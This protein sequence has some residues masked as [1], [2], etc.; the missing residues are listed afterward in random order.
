VKVTCGIDPGKL[1]ALAWISDVA[2]QVI[3]MPVIRAAKGRHEYDLPAIVSLLKRSHV[4]TTVYL[5]RGQPL[6][7]ILR[8]KPMGGASANYHRGY[9]RGL[10]EGILTALGIPY[11]LVSPRSWQKEMLQGTSGKD[12]KQRSVI[13]AQRLFPGV[14]LLPTE[15][16]RKASDGMA[17]SLLIAEHGRRARGG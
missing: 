6:P 8:G 12:T 17:D 7:R 2:V 13:A 9:S 11:V 4:S 3:P 5:E 1:G 15:R 16:F 10:F 14:S